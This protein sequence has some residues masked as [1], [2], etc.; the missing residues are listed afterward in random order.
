MNESPIIHHHLCM[1]VPLHIK[2]IFILLFS[3]VLL[4]AGIGGTLEISPAKPGVSSTLEFE[5]NSGE[6][7]SVTDKPLYAVAYF[8]NAT[9]MYPVAQSYQLKKSGKTYTAEVK[10]TPTDAVFALV[11]VTNGK[12]TDWNGD[13][14]WE[15]LFYDGKKPLNNAYLRQALSHLG[16]PITNIKR[17]VSFPLALKSLRSELDQNPDNF[18]AKIT[19]ASVLYETKEISKAE[20]TSR[21]EALIKGGYNA[22]KENEVRAAARAL[23][24]I[25]LPADASDIEKKFATKYPKTDL[26]EE[27][28]RV[29]C[30]QA[31][32][33]DEFE[34]AVR[35][36][37][38]AFNYG[39][40]GDGMYMDLLKFYL[41]QGNADKAIQIVRG[42]PVPPGVA[43]NPPASI[44]NMLAVTILQNDS[45]LTLAQQYAERAI[46]S[47]ESANTGFRPRFI[48]PV[49]FEYSNAE[50]LGISSDTYGYILRR[51][52]KLNEAIEAFKRSE[53][54]LGLDATGD[55]LE[56]QAEAQSAAGNMNDAAE[57]AR[58]AIKT[59]RALAP[60]VQ[61]FLSSTTETDKRQA[62]Y[63]ALLMQAKPFKKIKLNSEMMNWNIAS[64]TFAKKDDTAQ[65]RPHEIR[66][67]TMDGKNVTLADLKGKVVLIDFWATWCGPCRVSM[68]YMQKV[69]EKYKDNNQVQVVMCNVW[70]RAEDRKK[71]VQGFLEQNKDFSFPMFMDT[72]DELVGCFGVTGIPTKF[73]IDKN[74]IVQFKE[75]GFPGA[76]V[77]VE[78]TS[79][80]IDM[81]LNK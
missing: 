63:K 66:L 64:Q 65:L 62:E 38:K 55:M 60:T 61:R 48:S 75:V 24:S 30:M 78:D 46:R 58:R 21:V 70:E 3:P 10:D 14:M 49:E 73:Y 50:L 5:Y 51:K 29:S 43:S 9:Q 76:D 27:L 15:I 47:A 40:F 41:Q 22:D 69:Y 32:T 1:N 57:T 7:F 79:E 17:P 18:Q 80:K 11:K 2:S 28:M 68:P 26:A 52:N 74:G 81:L 12:Q 34:I 20:F 56:H 39:V 37:L 59:G 54:V 4:M 6:L 19:L 67:T 33:P 42:Y 71:V 8:Y 16:S 31:K 53:E 36:Y 44:L 13:N 77:F 35:D 72:T 45:L 23:Q 25:G